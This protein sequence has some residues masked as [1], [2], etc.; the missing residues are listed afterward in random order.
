MSSRRVMSKA[1]KM[2]ITWPCSLLTLLIRRGS[3]AGPGAAPC[4]VLSPGL[5]R[6]GPG[7]AHFATKRPALLPSESRQNPRSTKHSS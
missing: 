1:M 4:H 2:T 6:A 3:A 7:R 5:G